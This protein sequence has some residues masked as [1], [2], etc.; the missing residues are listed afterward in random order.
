[1]RN[2]LFHLLLIFITISLSIT[3]SF[4]ETNREKWEKMSPAQKQELREQYKRWQAMP[5]DQKEVLKKR[6]KK[7]QELSP[8][9]RQRARDNYNRFKKLPP[10]KKEK[11]K[12]FLKNWSKLSNK[13]KADRIEKL[14]MKKHERS[15]Q[16]DINKQ[17]RNGR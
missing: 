3:Y 11:V 16:R 2:I 14:K 4:A 12:S 8:E 6:F 15:V 9:E 17:R 1:M 7:F 10:D 5:E 13:E